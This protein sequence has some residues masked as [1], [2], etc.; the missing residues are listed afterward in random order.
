[1]NI[2]EQ[3]KNIL[4]KTKESETECKKKLEAI[5]ESLSEICNEVDNIELD[6]NSSELHQ[7]RLQII[8]DMR[9]LKQKALS[10]EGLDPMKVLEARQ[11]ITMW[12]TRGEYSARKIEIDI[13]NN[14]PIRLKAWLSINQENL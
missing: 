1:M 6:S 13:N 11:D 7:L 3:C 4:T 8:S 9:K 2:N 12:I 10:F 5:K 14:D